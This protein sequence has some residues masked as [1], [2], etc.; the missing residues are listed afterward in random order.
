M[1]KKRY[2]LNIAEYV[3]YGNLYAIWA[4]M[5]ATVIFRD[6]ID[7]ELLRKALEP[8]FKRMPYYKVRLAVAQCPERYI[9]ETNEAT[10]PIFLKNDYVAFNADGTNDYLI[11]IAC[12]GKKMLVNMSHLIS[13][14]CGLKR[15]ISALMAS[16]FSLRYGIEENNS[17]IKFLQQTPADSEYANPFDYIDEELIARAKPAAKKSD[18][19][20]RFTFPEDALSDEIHVFYLSIPKQ[21]IVELATSNDTSVAPVLSYI[22]FQTLLRLHGEENAPY[23]LRL[24]VDVRKILG[25]PEIMRNCTISSTLKLDPRMLKKDTFFQLTCLRGQI[26]SQTYDERALAKL[27]KNKLVHEKAAELDG[28]E[29]KTQFYNSLASLSDDPV[30][31]YYGSMDMEEYEQYYEDFRGIVYVG[32]RAGIF[33]SAIDEKGDFRIVASSSLKDWKRY[34][35]QM[36][37]IL[38]EIGIDL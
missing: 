20:L 16:Y 34:A 36:K 35:D 21:K 15:F 13:D 24:P 2:E 25:H 7:T 31:S 4:A 5:R 33:M 3:A 23:H 37:T 30:F 32:G 19:E 14:G 10:F 18:D 8:V 1:D 12:S 26:Y 6:E 29:M 38:G 22:L 9:L 27:M 11:T 17:W 28:I